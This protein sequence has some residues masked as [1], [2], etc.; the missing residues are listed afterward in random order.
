[1]GLIWKRF[2]LFHVCLVHLHSIEICFRLVG[3]ALEE[4]YAMEQSV[5]GADAPPRE[6]GEKG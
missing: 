3:V 4:T 2:D 6:E 1:M 5:P